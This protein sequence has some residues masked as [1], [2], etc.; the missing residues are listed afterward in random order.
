MLDYN[1]LL[2]FRHKKVINTMLISRKAIRVI[3]S[4]NCLVFMCK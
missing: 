4:S 2:S 3:L 1:A